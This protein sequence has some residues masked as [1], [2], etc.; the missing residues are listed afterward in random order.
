MK[1]LWAKI[2]I[3]IFLSAFVIYCGI[4]VTIFL[5]QRSLIYVPDKSFAEIPSIKDAAIT[6]AAITTQ[7]LNKLNG[8][9]ITSGKRPAQ[10]ILLFHGNGG[11]IS[12]RLDKALNYVRA[13]YGVLLAEYRGYGGNLGE[14]SETGLYRDARAYMKWL[15]ASGYEPKDII[16]YG[17]SLGTGVA[18]QIAS[19]TPPK[20]LILETPYA[21]LYEPAQKRYPFIPF[22]HLLMMDHYDSYAKIDKIKAPKLFLIAE[23][24]KVLGPETGLKLYKKAPQPKTL[25]VF[26]DGGHNNLGD[27]GAPQTVLAFLGTLKP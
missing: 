12:H 22:I 7:D 21:L 14:P 17:E 13:G 19:E 26:K 20:A 18:V 6:T 25:T 9:F 23:N 16:L 10:V 27:F 8:W 3:G 1:S 4:V 24:D 11:N 5:S 15:S 2:L